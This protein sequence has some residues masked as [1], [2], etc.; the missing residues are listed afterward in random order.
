MRP[1][2]KEAAVTHRDR[3]RRHGLAVAI[4]VVAS[5]L[6]VS[7]AAPGPAERESPEQPDRPPAAASPTRPVTD[8][9]R[10]ADGV[11]EAIVHE[12][13]LEGTFVY[14]DGNGPFPAVL[15]IAGS[16]PTDRDGNNPL[17]VMA[18]SYRKLADALAAAGIA[19]LRYDKRG[20]G[21]SVDIR[22]RESDMRFTTYIDDA[23]HWATWLS[24]QPGVGSV[25]LAGHSEGSLI[26]SVVAA[27]EPVA[28]VVL[29]AGAGRRIGDVL[30]AQLAAASAPTTL[31]AEANRILAELEAGRTVDMVN[32]ALFAIFRPS[33]QPFL[34][35]WLRLDPADEVRAIKAPLLIVRGGRDLQVGDADYQ[36]LAQ[37][38]PDAE[39]L[40]IDTMN[41]TLKDVGEGREAN[42]LGYSDPAPPL[43]H[44]LAERIVAFIVR[45]QAN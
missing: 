13:G 8:I 7:V 27:H 41:H 24:H 4:G 38:R 39:L 23:A 6:C 25:F 18:A 45:H 15:I 12:D 31:R 11:S 5:W 2:F 28:G 42:L 21:K 33:V 14:P 37:A 16:G 44:G 26:A 22:W 3:S 20:I 10:S 1:A 34:I 29:L 17:G 43:A 40:V 36:A 9:R 19:S 30:R 32:P 35:S